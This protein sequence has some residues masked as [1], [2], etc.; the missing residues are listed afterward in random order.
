MLDVDWCVHEADGV[1]LVAAVIENT[2]PVDRKVGLVSR[3]DGA[4]MPPRQ[5]G[6]PE[7]GWNEEGFEGV[8]PAKGRLSL[9]FAAKSPP[10]EPPVEI[11]DAGRATGGSDVAMESSSDRTP[12]DLLRDLGSPAPPRDAV[13]VAASGASA[14]ATGPG[15]G[16]HT[17]QP[18]PAPVTGWLDDVEERVDRA[19]RLA[20]PSAVDAATAATGDTGDPATVEALVADLAGDEAALR[21]VADRATELGERCAAREDVPADA[22]RRRA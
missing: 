16:G 15:T 10:E 14:P 1:M 19:E 6:L 11:A 7:S 9:G 20:D 17:D 5:R 22:D 8:V 21:A 12:T 4:V 2:A 3:L 18:V 13:P